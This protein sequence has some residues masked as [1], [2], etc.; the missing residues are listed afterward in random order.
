MGR[1]TYQMLGAMAGSPEGADPVSRRMDELAKTVLSHQ[2]SMPLPWTPARVVGGE[3]P[4]VIGQLRSEPGP[5]LRMIGSVTVVRDLAPLSCWT[6]SAWSS[7]LSCWG[8]TARSPSSRTT[9]ARRPGTG[10]QP[11][12]GQP[13]ARARLPATP[14]LRSDDARRRVHAWRDGPAQAAVGGVAVGV[15]GADLHGVR[16]GQVPWSVVTSQRPSP[17]TS[18]SVCAPSTPLDDRLRYTS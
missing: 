16:A 3:L 8:Q 14:T 18:D 7:S 5:M 17:S 4:E 10:G 15:A 1:R 12:P 13:A 2:A 9:C 11:H 6:S